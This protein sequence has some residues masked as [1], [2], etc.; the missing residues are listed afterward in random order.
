MSNVIV[1]FYITLSTSILIGLLMYIINLVSMDSIIT[2]VFIFS[3]DVHMEMLK[4]KVKVLS[5]MNRLF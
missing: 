3:Y 1:F 5:L 4:R 2:S